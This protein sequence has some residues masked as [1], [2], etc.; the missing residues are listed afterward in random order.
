MNILIAGGS[1]FIGK[2]LIHYLSKSN[3]ITVVGRNL[4]KLNTIF[5]N[6]INKITWDKLNTLDAHKIDIVLNLSGFNLGEKRWTDSIKK[7]IIASRVN[8]NH[9]LTQ[10]LIKEK[11]KP[12]FYSASAVGIY[13]ANDDLENLY[14]ENFL[15]P[16]L[17][18]DFIQ[19]IGLNWEN[20]LNE[21]RLACI[22]VTS[23]RFGIVLKKGEGM[24]KK[25]ELSFKLGLGSILGSGKQGI[26]WIYYQDLLAAIDFII[27]NPCLTGAINLCS[28]HPVSQKEFA[29]NFSKVL[30]KP[31]FIRMPSLI[32]KLLFGEMGEYLLLKGQGVFPKRLIDLGFSFSYPHLDKVFKNEYK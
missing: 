20:S 18:K 8:T 32:V 25:L 21:A 19:D 15:L 23:L 30:K 27:H 7:E 28:P 4:E 3:H 14:D 11:V 26:S 13:G 29:E 6:N 5:S 22:P 9:Q 17:A 24:L 10:W 31:L 1:G 16:S 12:H 2:L